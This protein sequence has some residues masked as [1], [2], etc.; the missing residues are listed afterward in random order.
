MKNHY[1]KII[2]ICAFV[3]LALGSAS[4]AP[5]PPQS[6][7]SAPRENPVKAILAA[8]NVC[9]ERL[10]NQPETK[11]VRKEIMPTP[12]QLSLLSPAQLYEFLNSPA[13]VTSTQYKQLAIYI[14][15]DMDCDNK[16]AASLSGTPYYHPRN[17]FNHKLHPL[18]KQLLNGTITIGYFNSVMKT[19]W[20]EY[21]MDWKQAVAWDELARMPALPS[22]KPIGGFGTTTC[23]GSGSSVTCNSFGY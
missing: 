21:D 13:R 7:Y 15:S 23:T 11:V 10:E 6:T 17:N 4:K 8:G 3:G 5:A 2:G 14:M 12:E 19:I 9:Y 1:L 16:L 22:F 20:N 18:Y